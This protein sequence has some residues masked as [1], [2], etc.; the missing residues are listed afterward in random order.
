MQKDSVIF[1]SG[2]LTLEGHSLVNYLKEQGY[3]KVLLESEHLS[4]DEVFISKTPEYVFLLGDSSGGISA[5]IEKPATLMIQNLHKMNKIIN[6]WIEC[7]KVRRI[8]HRGIKHFWVFSN[9]RP[10]PLNFNHR[11][12]N[13]TLPL[14][15]HNID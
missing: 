1:V 11:F 5:N 6:Q 7:Y 8:T 2:Y 10:Y 14:V 9:R 12:G 15:F 13:I 4:I 3:E